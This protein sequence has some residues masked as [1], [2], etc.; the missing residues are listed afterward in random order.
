M[1]GN[2]FE[3]DLDEKKYYGFHLAIVL[4]FYQKM[5]FS[6]LS[7]HGENNILVFLHFNYFL[8][9]FLFL[10]MCMKQGYTAST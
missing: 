3:I 9:I 1:S 4:S 5:F 8:F 10:T 6:F 7:S 2:N